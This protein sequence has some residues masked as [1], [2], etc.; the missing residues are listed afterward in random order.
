V[1]GWATMPY[2]LFIANPFKTCAW[3]GW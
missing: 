3:N 1:V 2:M